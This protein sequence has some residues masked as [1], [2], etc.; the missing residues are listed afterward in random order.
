MLRLH[1]RRRAIHHNPQMPISLTHFTGA[2]RWRIRQRVIAATLLRP[3]CNLAIQVIPNIVEPS[4]RLDR[5]RIKLIPPEYGSGPSS[6]KL[7]ISADPWSLTAAVVTVGSTLLTVIRAASSRFTVSRK[8]FPPSPG[9][10]VSASTETHSGIPP[11]PRSRSSGPSP[12]APQSQ[13]AAKTSVSPP[14]APC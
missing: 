14:G 8:A 1:C 4:T 13:S 2:S 3:L 12:P 5:Q 7:K 6:L 10:A 9:R 11:P